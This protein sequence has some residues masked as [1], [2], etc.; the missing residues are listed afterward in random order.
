[1]MFAILQIVE[2]LHLRRT[3]SPLGF[4]GQRTLNVNS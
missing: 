4:N 2:Q 3:L 1:M